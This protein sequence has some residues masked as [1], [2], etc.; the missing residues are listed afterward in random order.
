[1]NK[2]PAISAQ[3]PEMVLNAEPRPTPRRP[4]PVMIK[5]IPSKIHFN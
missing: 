2:T 3:I 4:R 5:K 1:M